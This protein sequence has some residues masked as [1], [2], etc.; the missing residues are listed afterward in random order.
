LIRYL[1]NCVMRNMTLLVNVSPDGHGVIPEIEQSRLRE[2]G[3]WLAKTG[4]AIYGTRGG[5]WNPVDRQYGYCF[6]GATVFAHLLR[7]YRGTS[8][9]MPAV[10]A[11]GV[12]NVYEVYSGKPLEYEGGSGEPVVIHGID[13]SDS[14]ADSIVGVEFERDVQDVWKK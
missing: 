14:P 9:T 11:F 4:D 10:G 6:K 1:A 2:M 12:R 13:R 7:D 5:P 8:F 3:K